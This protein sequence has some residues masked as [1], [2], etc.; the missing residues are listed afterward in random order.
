M[1]LLDLFGLNERQKQLRGQTNKEDRLGPG[2]QGEPHVIP[3]TEVGR[4]WV[5]GD[6]LV[7]G[8]RKYLR[9]P[10]V[11]QH[12]EGGCPLGQRGQVGRTR[13]VATVIEI[14]SAS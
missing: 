13:P 11:L 9:S 14:T 3:L 8:G 1:Q 7:I 2:M 12:P 4:R 6:R 5:E 10:G